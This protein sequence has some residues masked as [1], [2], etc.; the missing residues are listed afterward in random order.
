MAT[1]TVDSV[2]RRPTGLADTLSAV[3]DKEDRAG[4]PR[5]L[6]LPGP[7]VLTVKTKEKGKEPEKSRFTFQGNDTFTMTEEQGK[8]EL[9]IEFTRVK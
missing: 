8:K 4:S 1:C 6:G 2:A 9:K 3:P 5:T 7:G